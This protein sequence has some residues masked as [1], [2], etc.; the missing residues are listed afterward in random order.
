LKI[1]IT[2][3]CRIG[4]IS[5]RISARVLAE[6]LMMIMRRQKNRMIRIFGFEFGSSRMFLMLSSRPSIWAELNRLSFS[7]I[8]RLRVEDE[9]ES[10]E[11]LEAD[12]GLFVLIGEERGIVDAS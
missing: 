12:L 11:V 10:M 2:W 8:S 4:Q 1:L 3:D 5:F 9:A 6:D 7:L